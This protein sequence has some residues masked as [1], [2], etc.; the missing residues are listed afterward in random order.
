VRSGCSPAPLLELISCSRVVALVVV[1]V[2]ASAYMSM[3]CYFGVIPTASC[4]VMPSDHWLWVL[5]T[6]CLH[7]RYIVC[8]P[9]PFID[10][11]LSMVKL[12]ASYALPVTPIS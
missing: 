3:Q 2:V 9:K 10:V 12:T 7:C 1:A 4:A 8:I 5:W 6:L 11:F